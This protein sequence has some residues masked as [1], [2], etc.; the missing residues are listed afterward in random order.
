MNGRWSVGRRF[1]TSMMAFCYTLLVRVGFLKYIILLAI[2]T[3]R[4]RYDILSV[5]KALFIYN[6]L[7]GVDV[8]LAK[9]S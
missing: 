9:P 1:G 7:S 4:N 5:I 6:L 2:V 3:L 8:S